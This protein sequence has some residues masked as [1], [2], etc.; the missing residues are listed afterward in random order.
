MES[1]ICHFIR[2]HHDKYDG[3]TW[4][5]DPIERAR[6]IWE[7]WR[8]KRCTQLHHFTWAARLVALVQVSSASVERIFSQVKLIVETTGDNPLE[9][10]L[11]TR[12]MERCNVYSIV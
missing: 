4:K 5:D 8:A 3:V 7:W 9:E 2:H 1:H 6:R 12:L 11:T 10:T